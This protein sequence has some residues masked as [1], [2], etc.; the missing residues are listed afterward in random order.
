MWVD[1]S[2]SNA[3]GIPVY[4]PSLTRALHPCLL[5]VSAPR[6]PLHRGAL[7]NKQTNIFWSRFLTLQST[8]H[9][10][11]KEG[12]AQTT[13]SAQRG[14]DAHQCPAG[15]PTFPSPSSYFG[16]K[17]SV[18]PAQSTGCSRERQH[19]TQGRGLHLPPAARDPL[20]ILSPPAPLPKPQE[21]GASHPVPTGEAPSAARPPRCPAGPRRL[22][23]MLRDHGTAEGSDA[24]RGGP[25][26]QGEGGG[27]GGGEDAARR[28]RPPPRGRGT[29]LLT[30]PK[31]PT[32]S[33]SP[34]T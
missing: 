25:R 3:R 31:V 15:C 4:S 18:A 20:L 2:G 22:P 9:S 8:C 11:G 13:A 10:F 21:G 17:V 23:G 1:Y 16:R 28:A 30:L 27:G 6:E 26:W 5:Q 34:S 19:A 14:K 29:Q 7:K 12:A 32:P 24:R 33:V